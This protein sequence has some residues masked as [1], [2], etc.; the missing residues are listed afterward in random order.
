MGEANRRKKL[1][2][3]PEQT[4]KPKKPRRKKRGDLYEGYFPMMF[5]LMAIASQYPK[6]KE[7]ADDPKSR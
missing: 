4:N 3:Y 5:T 1:G 7:L 6:L 2:L